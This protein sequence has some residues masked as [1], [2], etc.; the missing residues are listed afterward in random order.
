MGKRMGINAENSSTV[1][2]ADIQGVKDEAKK[3]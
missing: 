3:K 2:A 1:S